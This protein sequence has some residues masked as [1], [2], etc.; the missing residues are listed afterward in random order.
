M[1]LVVLNAGPMTRYAESTAAQ[2]LDRRAYVDAVLGAQPV[3]PAWTPREG[4]KKP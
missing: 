3:P 1:L 2:L 4:M